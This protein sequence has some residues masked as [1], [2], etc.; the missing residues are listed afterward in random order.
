MDVGEVVI[1]PTDKEVDEK[2]KTYK[3][4]TGAALL[5][6]LFITGAYAILADS[7]MALEVLKITVFPF[8]GFAAAA[9][10]M[11]AYAKQIRN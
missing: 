2:T 3:R 4:E 7:D 9:W 11:D 6:S 1:T 5:G 10:G 8:I